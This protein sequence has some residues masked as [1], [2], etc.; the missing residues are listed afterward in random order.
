MSRFGRACATTTERLAD[1]LD[2]AG[3]TVGSLGRLVNDREGE[4]WEGKRMVG[5][6]EVE[7][8]GAPT[9]HLGP[10]RPLTPIPGQ[11]DDALRGSPVVPHH[12]DRDQV[13][14]SPRVAHRPFY[15]TRPSRSAHA[16]RSSD[17]DRRS[18][19]RS[20]SLYQPSRCPSRRRRR[21]C[22]RRAARPRSSRRS[23]RLRGATAARTARPDPRVADWA[24]R[25]SSGWRGGSPRS[26]TRACTTSSTG[27]C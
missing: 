20:S 27:R 6:M 16:D 15:F 8:V 9:F 14:P 23:R 17:H 11:L 24:P 2:A 1:P 3:A 19:R 7:D 5:R 25:V 26:R 12:H 10:R 18:S 4:L 13:I 22:S 21:S